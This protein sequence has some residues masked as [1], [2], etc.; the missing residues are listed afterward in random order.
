MEK[1][2]EDPLKK[3]IIFKQ[4]VEREKELAK[5]SNELNKE[6]IKKLK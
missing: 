4:E 6:L 2:K 1:K 3:A 5:L